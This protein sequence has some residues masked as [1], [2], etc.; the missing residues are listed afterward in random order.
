MASIWVLYNIICIY[1]IIPNNIHK[2][3]LDYRENTTFGVCQNDLFII[4][5]VHPDNMRN[6]CS[7][8][9]L[10][11]ESN[12]LTSSNHASWL[13]N[14]R[15]GGSLGVQCHQLFGSPNWFPSQKSTADE[16]TD[17]T[18][19]PKRSECHI[20]APFQLI[21]GSSIQSNQ[22]IVRSGPNSWHGRQAPKQ[23]DVFFIFFHHRHLLTTLLCPKV[24]STQ[25]D[26]RLPGAKKWLI[27]TDHG[28][29][30]WFRLVMLVWELVPPW[31]VVCI[32]LQNT[33]NTL[34]TL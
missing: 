21:G 15:H 1:I 6:K 33:N 14:V 11:R 4:V 8:G 2:S 16:N 31:C 20:S 17:P 7:L 26:L 13:A 27:L 12:H 28:W 25:K 32:A 29:V 9:A 24:K 3:W 18:S 19:F 34:Y 23:I 5:G 10:Q 22:S 30:H